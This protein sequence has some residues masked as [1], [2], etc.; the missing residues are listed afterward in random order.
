MTGKDESFCLENITDPRPSSVYLNEFKELN[1]LEIMVF[2]SSSNPEGPKASDNCF[3]IFK[4]F[5]ILT[6][7]IYK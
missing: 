1:S 3:R 5:I 7:K 2:T 4:L 6:F